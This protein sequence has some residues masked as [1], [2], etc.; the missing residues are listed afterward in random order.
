VQQIAALEARI[1]AGPASG[2]GV[3]EKTLLIRPGSEFVTRTFAA[4]DFA[5]PVRS[6]D[7]IKVHARVESAGNSSCAVAVWC[8][9]AETRQTV[10]R[11]GLPPKVDPGNMRVGGA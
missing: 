2:F 8:V 3:H 1:A 11:T 9:N 4:F 5:N 10:F 6:G 7:I